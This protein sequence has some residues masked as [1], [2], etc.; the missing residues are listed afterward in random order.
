MSRSRT[1]RTDADSTSVLSAL[2]QQ[3][4]RRNTLCGRNA[5]I[6]P[7]TERSDRDSDRD[8]LSANRRA[9]RR[10]AVDLRG[11]TALRGRTTN[12]HLPTHA[13]RD[14]DRLLGRRARVFAQASHRGEKSAPGSTPGLIRTVVSAGATANRSAIAPVHRYS[15][16]YDDGFDTGSSLLRHRL[17]TSLVAGTARRRRRPHWPSVIGHL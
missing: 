3:I 12:E 13:R 4:Q 16:P 17:T 14:R 1:E 5:E 6:G 15:R 9:R 10:R 8:L 7:I 2:Q 11:P